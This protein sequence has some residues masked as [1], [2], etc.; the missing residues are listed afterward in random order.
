MA[1]RLPQLP[2]YKPGRDGQTNHTSYS[3]PSQRALSPRV[4]AAALRTPGSPAA[5]VP[6]IQE[7][8][9]PPFL[10]LLSFQC[11]RDQSPCFPVSVRAVAEPSRPYL[12]S[13][14]VT[15]ATALTEP[16]VSIHHA[17]TSPVRSLPRP[18]PILPWPWFILVPCPALGVRVS[19]DLVIQ[20]PFLVSVPEPWFSEGAQVVQQPSRVI[21]LPFRE[22]QRYSEC[23]SLLQGSSDQRC[24][25]L[26]TYSV[27]LRIFSSLF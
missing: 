16:S 9:P 20:G 15:R 12:H 22:I 19:L 26:A 6:C 14:S 17:C 7:S 5:F 25:T 1:L 2:L 8:P 4:T 21:Q 18:E 27:S 10:E 3:F 13:A 23:F 24:R 11:R